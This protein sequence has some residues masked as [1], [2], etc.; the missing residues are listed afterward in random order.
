MGH[1]S[2]VARQSNGLV[3]LPSPHCRRHRTWNGLALILLVAGCGGSPASPEASDEPGPTAATPAPRPT[4]SP[5]TPVEPTWDP[6]ACGVTVVDGVRYVDRCQAWVSQVEGEGFGYRVR[7]GDLPS[8]PKVASGSICN[9]SE[10]RCNT[11]IRLLDASDHGMLVPDSHTWM[12]DVDGE[13]L[14][15]VGFD[16]VGAIGTTDEPLIADRDEYGLVALGEPDAPPERVT[17]DHPGLL[18]DVETYRVVTHWCGDVTG[19]GRDDLCHRAYTTRVYEGPVTRDSEP[20]MT[21]AGPFEPGEFGAFGSFRPEEPALVFG[22]YWFEDFRGG[23]AHLPLTAGDHPI[24]TAD[25]RLVGAEPGARV[26]DGMGAGDLDGDGDD[27]LVVGQT[28][29]DER[30]GAVKVY[31]DTPDDPFGVLLLELAGQ[32][33]HRRFGWEALVDDLDGDG[34]TDLV[35]AAPGSLLLNLPGLVHV[36]PGPIEQMSWDSAVTWT[37]GAGHWDKFGV[38]LAALD[39]DGD[40]DLELFV[41]A[42]H[43]SEVAYRAGAVFFI[44]DPLSAL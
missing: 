13:G 40:G 6:G 2:R 10:A 19:N 22:Y 34:H 11:G 24:E 8:G 23:I 33:P 4:P 39:T 5:P 18:F 27:E 17:P 15:G 9:L 42:P 43:F 28:F 35:V 16:F 37:S 21:A 3:N 12:R 26:G 44:E 32:V 36:F 41:G 29:E 38:S 1:L 20:W 30:T 7:S 25:I 31:G 14:L